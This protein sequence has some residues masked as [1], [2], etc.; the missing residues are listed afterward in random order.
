MDALLLPFRLIYR[1][2]VWFANSPRTLIVSYLLMIVVA[3]V[4]YSHAE[5]KS[6]ADSV[7]WAVVTASTVG[8]GDISPTTVAGRFLAALLISTMV[9]LVIPLITAHFASRL[10]VDDD[11][12]EHD[13]QEE[14]KADVRRLRALLEE[15]AARQGIEVPEPEPR[16][17]A[18]G[19]GSDDP[20][21]ERSARRR[22]RRGR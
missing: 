2:L 11:A 22:R 8:Y 15:M 20:L 12:F 5:H 9:L 7:W 16:P 4:L 14:L 10:I 1:G 6:A 3:G 19:P 17:P 18:H 13:E 21:W